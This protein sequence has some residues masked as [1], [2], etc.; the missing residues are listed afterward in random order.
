MSLKIISLPATFRFTAITV[1]I[2]SLLP[3]DSARA[4]DD[5]TPRKAAE[6]KSSEISRSFDQ[7]IQPLLKKY[8]VRCH[9]AKKMT[10]GIRLDHLNGALEDGQLFLWKDILKQ[11][12]DEA[13]PPDDQPQPTAEHRQLLVGWIRQG[14]IAA[15]SRIPQK[16]GAVRRLTVSQ[17]RNTLR[18]LLGLEENLTD[19]LPPDAMSKEGFVNNS[20]SMVLSPLLIEAYFDV[21]EKA[22]DL[23]IID[24]KSKPVVQNFRMD[25]GANINPKP[26][27]EKLI[28][29]AN[30]RLLENKN[31]LVS[32]L[33]PSKPFEFEPFKMRTKY[34]F[35][36]GYRGN[37][38]V[39]GWREYDSIYHALF[40]CMR[41]TD[42]YPKGKAYE[43][44]PEGLLLRPAI[45]SAELFQVESTY[46]PKANFKISLR[47]L[48][49]QGQFRVTVKA[50]RYDDALLLNPGQS[51]RPESTPGAITARQL[52]NPQTVTIKKAGIYQANVFLT[53]PSLD[54]T[55]A[56][57]D[58]LA[59]GLIGAWPLNGDTQSESKRE[60]LTGRL[61]GGAQF[62]DSPFGKALSLDGK[63]D[64]LVVDRDNSMNVGTGDFS[65]AAWIHPTELRQGGIVCLGRYSWTHGW[66]FDMPNNQGVLRIETVSPGNKPNGT[67]ASRPGVIRVN[68]WQHVAA[69]VRR[70]TNKTNLYVNG[71][72]VATGTVAPT[73]LDNPSVKLHLGRIE[74]SK[75]FKG[76]I[77]DV[78]IYRRALDISEIKALLSPGRQFIKP[79]PPEKPQSLTLQLGQRQF[80]ATLRQPAFVAL[81]LPAGP[82]P[83][84]VQY[85]G[86]SVPHRIVLTPLAE[87]NELAK[88]F[89]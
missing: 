31:F 55:P 82:L 50:A 71:Y 27:P 46:G 40:A 32:E 63:E 61:E 38:T 67:V 54:S 60:V 64:S 28:L 35:I 24:E 53:A 26:F 80:S 18:A 22:L 62:V 51:S 8:C 14:M 81:R 74:G 36:E 29:G 76:A 75:L 47:Q 20:R 41:G 4:E 2:L 43:S 83:M 44:I 10:S 73:N 37:D 52:A 9:N 19:V 15:K 12:A 59:E 89:Q 23:C 1:T 6:S 17:Y 5:Q 58:K 7:K 56:K 79:P 84:Q 85:G 33:T 25:L 88:E 49:E 77:D 86:S 57:A 68:R 3:L 42:G 30:S 16:N 65:V 13:M 70:G 34:R 45:P 48:P 66:Y 69:V 87:N 39:R 72:L 21:A 11:V 78:R